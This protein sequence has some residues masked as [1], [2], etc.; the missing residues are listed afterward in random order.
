MY[1]DFSS[2]QH[3]NSAQR[4]NRGPA[5]TLGKP[6][7]VP[8]RRVWG[9]DGL[10]SKNHLFLYRKVPTAIDGGGDVRLSNWILNTKDSCKMGVFVILCILSIRSPF[11]VTVATPYRSD[12]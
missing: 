6:K 3:L 1:L 2:C 11:G 4:G 7:K 5:I 10:F 12:T 9:R 8:L